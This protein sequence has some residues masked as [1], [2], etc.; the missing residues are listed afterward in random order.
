[1]IVKPALIEHDVA[2]LGAKRHL[3]VSASRLEAVLHATTGIL[4][5]LDDLA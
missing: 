3:T 4:I 2:A 1:M 5:K